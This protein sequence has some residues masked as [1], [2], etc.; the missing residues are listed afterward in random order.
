MRIK[1]KKTDHRRK[2]KIPNLSPTFY[3][4]QQKT[5]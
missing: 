4:I 2:E 3:K 1:F 5:F